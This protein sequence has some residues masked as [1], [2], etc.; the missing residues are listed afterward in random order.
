MIVTNNKKPENC[1]I[2]INAE[3][4]LN[5]RSTTYVRLAN[6]DYNPLV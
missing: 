5:V 4:E 6:N 3:R 1:D 2:F